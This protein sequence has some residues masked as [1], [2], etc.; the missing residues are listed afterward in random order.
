MKIA[1]VGGSGF[2]GRNL[3][4]ALHSAGE[5]VIIFSRKN[6]LPQEL[7]GLANIHLVSTSK[8]S[9][10]DLEGIDALVNLAGESVVG[11]KWSDKRKEALRTSRVDFTRSIVEELAKVKVKP[12]VLLQG[13]AIGFYGMHETG[14]PVFSE[15]AK[16]GEDF[17]AKLCVDWE[18]E[19]NRAKDFGV[20]TVLI[21]TGIVLS[22]ESGAMQQMLLPF[23]MFVGGPLGNG[24]QYMSWIH[25]ADMI[26]AIQF[27]LA[28][29]KAEGAFN[30]TAPNPCSNEE[31]STV[32]GKVMGRPSFM[33][34]PSFPLI[35]LYGEGA[36]VILKG[37][38]VIP[39]KLAAFGYQFQFSE[40]KNALEDLLK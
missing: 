34:V 31:F 24:K 37:Q 9:A 8:P 23:K 29:P 18:E 26:G 35:A 14:K 16:S 1:I 22:P 13:S 4:K 11:E 28:N 33:R 7:M 20:R 30:F 27:L 38:N 25:L 39:A 19:A 36:E 21:R 10:K 6:S 2:I 15:D 3:A 32:L 12:K 5:E 40:L 17:L